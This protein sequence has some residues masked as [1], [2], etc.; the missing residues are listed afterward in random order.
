MKV[1]DRIN[2]AKRRFHDYKYERMTKKTASVQEE[3]MR[4]EREAAQK[5]LYD[6]EVRKNEELRER[7]GQRKPFLNFGSMDPPRSFNVDTFQTR[8]QGLKERKR[9]FGR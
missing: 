9:M 6:Q 5:E 2:E 4:L 1:L 3:N 7:M 8:E